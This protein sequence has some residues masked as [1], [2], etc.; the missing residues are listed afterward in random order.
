[1]VVSRAGCLTRVWSSNPTSPEAL[2][3]LSH[4]MISVTPK[5]LAMTET[6]LP[7]NGWGD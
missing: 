2:N 6:R 7:S 4:M 5:A 3:R 1:L